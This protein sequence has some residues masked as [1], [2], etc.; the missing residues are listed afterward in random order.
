MQ[1]HGDAALVWLILVPL[2]LGVG[3]WLLIYSR[4]RSDLLR[5]FAQRHGLIYRPKDGGG[6]EKTL[7]EALRLKPPCGRAF[8]RLRDIVSDTRVTLARLTEALDLSP[9][10]TPQSTHHARTAALF[11]APEAADL[12]FQV[13]RDGKYVW[14]HPERDAP[15][16]D[17]YFEAAFDAVASRPPPHPLSVTCMNGQGLVYLEPPLVGSEKE[18]ELQ[19]LLELARK[20]RQALS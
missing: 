9:Y 5:R 8:F 13:T 11:D 17:R 1:T 20:L 15:G 16:G 14:R 4:R 18:P 10:G 3:V 6:L 19:Y 12:Y 7:C 2:F